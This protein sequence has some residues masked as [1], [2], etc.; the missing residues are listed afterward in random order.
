MKSWI[1]ISLSDFH[2]PE[3]KWQ[4]GDNESVRVSVIGA[5]NLEQAKKTARACN[6][7]AW[8]V[9]PLGSTKNIAY[10]E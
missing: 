1:A 8:M 10:K 3:K 5:R 7:D 2:N 6:D 4:R 9:F